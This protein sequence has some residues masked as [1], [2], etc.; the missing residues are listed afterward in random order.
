MQVH[1]DP[2]PPRHEDRERRR[3]G[4]GRGPDQRELRGEPPPARDALGP[5]EAVGPLLQ[6][7]CD[8]WRAPEQSDQQGDHQ[9]QRDHELQAAVLL[10]ELVGELAAVAPR[11]RETGRQAGRRERVLDPGVGREEEQAHRTQRDRAGE[12]LLPMLPP[13]EPDHAPTSI[14]LRGSGP[15][16]ALAVGSDRYA[17]T[18]SSSDTGRAAHAG[19]A[20]GP[21]PRTNNVD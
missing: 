8:E 10:V 21:A 2:A 6:F 7:A 17:R 5:H 15:G 20:M 1:E 19:S 12:R 4:H 16:S 13:G 18:R 11:R 3:P 14:L 9:E